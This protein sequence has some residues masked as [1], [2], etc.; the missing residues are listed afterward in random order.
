MRWHGSEWTTGHI[1]VKE[2]AGTVC[3]VHSSDGTG[4]APYKL[5]A[6]WWMGGRRG[7]GGAP[8]KEVFS[9]FSPNIRLAISTHR[10]GIF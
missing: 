2:E 3:S 10:M 8:V 6:G 9:F 4:C 1:L 7:G 5:T